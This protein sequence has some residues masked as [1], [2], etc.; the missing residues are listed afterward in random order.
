LVSDRGGLPL[1]AAVTVANVND[2][3]V[4]AALLDDVPAVLTPD[5]RRRSRPGK[6]D[7]DKATTVPPTV[8]GCAV[9]G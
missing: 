7:A 4:F 2:T 8:P 6:V 1:T 9:V 3:S 5:R